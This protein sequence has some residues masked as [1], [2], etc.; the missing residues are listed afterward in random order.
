M[1]RFYPTQAVAH[2]RDL[3][4]NHLQE[5]GITMILSDLDNTLVKDGEIE[6]S[7]ELVAWLQQLAERNIKIIIVSNNKSEKRV[8]D[9]AEPLGLEYY[10]K[11]GKPNPKVF[12]HI[13]RKHQQTPEQTVMLGDRLTTDVYG[14][15]KLGMHTVL[16]E[17]IDPHEPFGIR[18]MRIIER[19]IRIG[20]R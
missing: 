2:F 4:L 19:T 8:K 14:G 17:P 7:S 20:M 16:V 6:S 15:N 18:L 3:N 9:F 10:Y 5:Q 11:A 12:E 1:K 13:F